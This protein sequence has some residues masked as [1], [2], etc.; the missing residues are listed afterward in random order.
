M[1]AERVGLRDALV[2]QQAEQ[3]LRVARL[4]ALVGQVDPAACAHPGSVREETL[5]HESPKPRA[6]WV[7]TA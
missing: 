7:T 3:V 6:V 1:A 4:V 2:D 5:P